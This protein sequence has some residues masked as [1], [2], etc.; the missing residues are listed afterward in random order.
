MQVNSI[1][2]NYQKQQSFGALIS[3]MSKDELRKLLKFTSTAQE[4]VDFFRED[5]ALATKIPAQDIASRFRAIKAICKDGQ[6]FDPLVDAICVN[7]SQEQATLRLFVNIPYQ[8]GSKSIDI[9]KTNK[10]SP[11]SFLERFLAQ[12]QEI[13][14]S[15]QKPEDVEKASNIGLDGF[16]KLA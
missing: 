8:K 1:N 15:L 9:V 4:L 7:P 12:I 10:E 14:N 11:K 16:F 2:N 6:E 5:N 13:A 3:M